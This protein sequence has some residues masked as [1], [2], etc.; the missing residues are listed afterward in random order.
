MYEVSQMY[1]SRVGGYTCTSV[2]TRESKKLNIYTE[3]QYTGN[4]ELRLKDFFVSFLF[5]GNKFRDTSCVF[6]NRDT[7]ISPLSRIHTLP[8]GMGKDE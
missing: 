7:K 6:A 2:S 1:V 5:Q 3:P 4:S 8:V